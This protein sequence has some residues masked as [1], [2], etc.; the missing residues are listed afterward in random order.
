[1]LVLGVL[2]VGTP[3]WG[4]AVLE[5]TEPG[6]G[7]TVVQPP[8][9]VTL[10]FSESVQISLGGIRAFDSR[11]R[12]IDVGEPEHP[13][14]VARQV[15]AS[16]PELDDGTYVITWRVT[17]V[18]SHPIRG[19]FTFSVGA[20]DAS[21]REA[22]GLAQRLLTDQGGSTVVGAGMALARM[23]VFL[24]VTVLIGAAGFLAVVWRAGR[25]DRRARRVVWAAWGVA[26]GATVIGFALQG[27]Y[28]AGEGLAKAFDPSLWSEVLDT[29]FGRVWALRALILLVSFPLLR[30]LMPRGPAAE[31]PLPAWW[32]AL[33]GVAGVALA[34]TPAFAGHPVS[35]R[36]VPLAVPADTLHVAAVGLWLG[37]LVMLGVALLRRGDEDTL[38]TVVPRYSSYA[39]VAVALIVVSGAFQMIR[40]VDRLGALTDTDYGRLLSIKLIVFVGLLAVAAYSRDVVNRRWRVPVG[41]AHASAVGSGGGLALADPDLAQEY[42]DGY[43]LE[44]PVAERRLRRSV[45]VE[46]AISAV[47]LAVTALLVDAAPPVEQSSGPFQAV[48]TAD[49]VRI[50]T[51][52]TPARRGANE[53]HLTALTPSGA[54]QDTI[55]MT[56]QLSQSDNDIAPI[57]IRLVRAG[58]GHYI[59]RSFVVPFAGD[60]DLTVKAL[61]TDVQEVTATAE[62]PVR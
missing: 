33:A 6:A 10:T 45:V 1:V 58:P 5:E 23:G 8:D 28:V 39:L 55:D 38:R 31:H 47:I 51:V 27:P 26:L 29:R 25:S 49:D 48:L 7:A 30:M 2:L 61:I 11:G 42:P 9:A 18:D 16:L 46:L 41:V 13:D 56:A 43:V 35:G 36:W 17:S 40:Q 15:R 14:G 21:S 44:E 54:L 34:A 3:A 32:P 24:G 20:A 19:A 52:L 37:G 22:S 62:I 12:R 50:D 57:D 53:L 59:S 4:H 60:W